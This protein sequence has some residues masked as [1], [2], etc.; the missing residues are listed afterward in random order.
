MSGICGVIGLSP[1]ALSDTIVCSMLQSMQHRGSD[2]VSCCTNNAAGVAF[3]QRHLN[4]FVADTYPPASGLVHTDGLVAAVDGGVIN[5]AEVLPHLPISSLPQGANQ[6]VKAVVAAYQ[7][8]GEAGLARLDG[9]FSFALWD[10]QKRQLLLSRDK[11]GEKSLYY[12]VDARRETVVFASGVKAIL[13]HP[14]VR[15]ELDLDSLSLYF[16]FG[17]IPGP[18]TLFKG[19]NKLLPGENLHYEHTNQPQTR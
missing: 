4:A 18:R 1:T 19:I 13:A 16:A 14:T 8:S 12:Y 10:G 11:L 15:A 2:S 9:P 6:D 17:Y 7:T 5:R 3:G